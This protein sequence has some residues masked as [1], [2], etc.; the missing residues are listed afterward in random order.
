MKFKFKNASIRTTASRSVR[1]LFLKKINLI[2]GIC[3][4]RIQYKCFDRIKLKNP[5][6]WIFFPFDHQKRLGSSLNER[7]NDDRKF[8]RSTSGPHRR[9]RYPAWFVTLSLSLSVSLRF[10]YNFFVPCPTYRKFPLT[11]FSLTCRRWANRIWRLLQMISRK[12]L[13]TTINLSLNKFISK[14]RPRQ[15]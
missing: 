5:T 12:I 1:N 15:F 8:E 14:S 4:W 11:T 13:L 10:S 6:R 2:G 7:L 3:R 9:P